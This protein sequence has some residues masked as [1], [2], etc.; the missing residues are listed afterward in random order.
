[1]TKIMV[2]VEKIL[3][4][5]KDVI[6]E[7]GMLLITFVLKTNEKVMALTTVTMTMRL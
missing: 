5:G 1:M 2:A 7:L 4:V 6:Y 3:Y